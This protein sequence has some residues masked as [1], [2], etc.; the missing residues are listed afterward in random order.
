MFILA[1]WRPGNEA[2]A[3]Y[4]NLPVIHPW[5]RNQVAP[6]EKDGLFSSSLIFHSKIR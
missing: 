6:Q 2:I 3:L 1:G 4:R 5:V